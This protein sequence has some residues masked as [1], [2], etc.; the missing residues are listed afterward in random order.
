M[1]LFL[2]L[3]QV[4][5]QDPI[6]NWTFQRTER[7][8]RTGREEVPFVIK[9]EEAV[10]ID[11]QKKIFDVRGVEAVYYTEPRKDERSEKVVLRAGHGHFDDTARSLSLDRGVRI[12]REDGTTLEAPSAQLDLAKQ[13]LYVPRGFRLGGPEALLEGDEVNSDL[14]EALR[15]TR[16]ARNGTLKLTGRARDLAPAAGPPRAS[17]KKLVTKLASKGPMTIREP[18]DPAEPV[19]VDASGGVRVERLDPAGTASMTCETLETWAFRRA[20]PVSGRSSLHLERLDARGPL[21]F[22]GSSFADGGTYSGEADALSWTLD[23]R[24]D[25][26]EDVAVFANARFR[27]GPTGIR[28]ARAVLERLEGRA[29]FE[30]SVESTFVPGRDPAA[31]PVTLRSDRLATRA[32]PGTSAPESIEATGNVLLEGL[33]ERGGRAEADRF[34]WSP[35]DERGFLEKRPFVRVVQEGSLIQAP[36]IVLEGSSR[37][38]LK[39]PKQVRLLQPA[40]DGKVAEYRVTCEGDLVV[41]SSGGAT[42][43]RLRDRCTVRT[44]DF[45]LFADR[46]DVRTSADGKQVESLRAADGVRL[47]QPKD[48]AVMAGDRLR[49]DPSTQR[50]HLTGRPDA[51]IET[52]RTT[53]FQER[54]EFYTEVDPRTG[55]K[56]QFMRMIG[57][58]RGVRLV[59]DEKPR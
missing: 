17:A 59:L 32:A 22:E 4:S 19:R 44:Q 16:I 15:E 48:S 11:L 45:H 7:N 35:A 8:P 40:E 34:V 14:R 18:K 26:V 25:R 41:D 20:D 38:V 31:K 28:S 21:R 57:G 10:P 9:G 23:D 33:G 42:E 12:L 53:A 56:Q 47:V 43:I 46:V 58:A 51:V 13:S 50:L 5:P 37:V 24:T 54:V 2:L 55:R 36:L 39:G 1:M 3:L 6:R 27:Q 29:T 30:G 52:P 49:M